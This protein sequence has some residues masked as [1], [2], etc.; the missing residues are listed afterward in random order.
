[1]TDWG[2]VVQLETLSHHGIRYAKAV[3]NLSCQSMLSHSISFFLG[4]FALSFYHF[5][6]CPKIW[7]V[8]LSA[9]MHACW[10]LNVSVF[11]SSFPNQPPKPPSPFPV[12]YSQTFSVR[13]VCICEAPLHTLVLFTFREF[14][15]QLL[16]D[17]LNISQPER[18]KEPLESINALFCTEAQ[19]WYFY[20]NVLIQHKYFRHLVCGFLDCC[21]K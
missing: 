1:M 8:T 20:Q 7:C 13:L 12:S 3:S 10:L 5:F 6:L 9:S 17:L 21:P 14:S 4:S 16:D 11:F 2:T 18:F 15:S 19:V